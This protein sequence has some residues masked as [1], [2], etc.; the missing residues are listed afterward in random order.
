MYPNVGINYRANNM[1]LAGHSNA[2][3]HNEI[4]AHS[5]AGYQI[6]LSEEVPIPSNKG[7][8]LTLVQ[9][10][11]FVMSS[12]AT[13]ELAALFITAKQMSTLRQILIEMGFPQPWLALQTENLTAAGVTNNTTIPK[14]TKA[15]YIRFHWICCRDS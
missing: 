13:P 11:K 7:P 14:G 6:F 5:Q 1:V 4:N 12:I 8:L 10:I 9:V 15:M 2:S 3:Y